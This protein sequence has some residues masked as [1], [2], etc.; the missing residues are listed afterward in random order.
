MTYRSL[1]VPI[2]TGLLFLSVW[3]HRDAAAYCGNL[4][5]QSVSVG[6]MQANTNNMDC[7]TFTTCNYNFYTNAYHDNGERLALPYCKQI[8]FLPAGSSFNI[9]A[10]G[11]IEDTST[12]RC[13]DFWLQ[14]ELVAG[15]GGQCSSV[16]G[17]NYTWSSNYLVNTCAVGGSNSATWKFRGTT[18]L[19]HYGVGY[20]DYYSVNTR[21][22]L[23]IGN[24]VYRLESEDNGR[25][26]VS[27]NNQ[28][29]CV[30]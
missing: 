19:T 11:V 23:G 21:G 7:G 5:N 8:G 13:W 6:E 20:A 15:Y 29:L 10:P 2:T 17:T 27:N 3:T 1:L 24:G 22:W 26:L 14:L 18:Q 12:S 25:F 28:G 16:N 9:V 4:G 30:D